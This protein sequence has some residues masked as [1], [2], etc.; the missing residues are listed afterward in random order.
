MKSYCRDSTE[1]SLLF[2]FNYQ[3]EQAESLTVEKLAQ[4]LNISLSLALERL[5]TTERAGKVCRDESIEGLQFF[6]NRLLE[7]SID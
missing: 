4:I 7:N 6:P 1:Y 2:L 3:V 5:L